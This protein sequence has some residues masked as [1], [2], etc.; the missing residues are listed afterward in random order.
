MRAITSLPPPAA[1]P[2]MMW[3]G[4]VGY[5]AG[6]SCADAAVAK[7]RAQRP[8]TAR[9]N[10]TIPSKP[11]HM[12][13]Q[14]R[15]LAVVECGEAA[16]DGGNQFVRLADAFAVSTEGLGNFRKI[17]PLALAARHQPRLERVG[18]GGNALGVDALG[19]RLHR[20]P[21]AIVDHDRE[22]R[23]LVLLC[24]RIDAV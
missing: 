11:R 3:I 22:N 13:M 14:H 10:I 6:S 4:R 16:V 19:G 21:A 15:G 7:T 12:N 5:F 24:D 17:A 2:T 9:K 1:K 23:D 18:L 20:L 8:K